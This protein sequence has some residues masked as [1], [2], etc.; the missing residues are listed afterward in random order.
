MTYRKRIKQMDVLY[1]IIIA[2][3]IVGLLGCTKSE[4]RKEKLPKEYN[5][6]SMPNPKLWKPDILLGGRINEADLRILK[7]IGYRMIVNMRMPQEMS[8]NEKR[9]VEKLGMQYVSLPIAGAHGFTEENAHKLAK[10]LQKKNKPILLHCA[11]GNRVG[12]MLALKA[13]YIDK[14]SKKES[15]EIGSQAGMK[16]FLRSF[17]ARKLKRAQ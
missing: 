16:F 11:S 10:L 7:K 9:Y 6:L 17:L 2:L 8:W 1:I 5:G 12:A 13:F 3:V 15:I 4:K 14:K